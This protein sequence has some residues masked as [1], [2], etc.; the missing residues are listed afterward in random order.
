[1]DMTWT[2][3]LSKNEVRTGAGYESTVTYKKGIH[4]LIVKYG[5]I[6]EVQKIRVESNFGKSSMVSDYAANERLKAIQ[7]FKNLILN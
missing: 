5:F 6:G 3:E 7:T 2:K 1:M 4:A